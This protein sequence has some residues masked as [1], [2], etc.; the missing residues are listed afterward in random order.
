MASYC[1]S[2]PNVDR[3][4]WDIT[5]E[6]PLLNPLG[7]VR[8]VDDPPLRGAW[9]TYRQINLPIAI[10]ICGHRKVSA[11]PIRRLERWQP[12]TIGIGS[13]SLTLLDKIDFSEV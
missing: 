7:S 11:I 1:I 13:Q 10:V 5:I 4:Y 12:I 9:T 3:R 8:A 2:I 6:S